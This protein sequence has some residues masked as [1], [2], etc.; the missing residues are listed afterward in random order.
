MALLAI[1]LIASGCHPAVPEHTLSQLQAL[2]GC[3]VLLVGHKGFGIESMPFLLGT[4]WAPE[5]TAVRPGR[6]TSY[7]PAVLQVGTW[8]GIRLF[9]TRMGSSVPTRNRALRR[10]GNR[11]QCWK[12]QLS[13]DIPVTV[14]RGGQPAR[15]C[16]DFSDFFTGKVGLSIPTVHWGN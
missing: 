16:V 13:E 1:V 2:E 6:S 11:T 5:V 7:C 15:G 10:G 8:R 4:R 9:R 3:V 14:T 12:M